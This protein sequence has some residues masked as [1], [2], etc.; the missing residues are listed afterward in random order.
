MTTDTPATERRCD[1]CDEK[2]T[3]DERFHD[4]GHEIAHVDCVRNWFRRNYGRET[5]AR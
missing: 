4:D 1:I 2:I 3:A 5:L